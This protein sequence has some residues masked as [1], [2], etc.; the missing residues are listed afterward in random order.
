M[1]VNKSGIWSEA[2]VPGLALGGVSIAYLAINSFTSG[3]AA[4]GT[5]AFLVGFLNFFLW[6]GKLVLCIW[7]LRLF[8]LKFSERRP[9]AGVREIFRY[10]M[11]IALLSSLLYSVFY[12]A[13]VLY[14][15][16]DIIT[17]SFDT[18]LQQYAPMMDQASLEAVENMKSDMPV[19]TFIV[20]LI[21]CFLFGTVLSSIFARRISGGSDNP[22]IDEQ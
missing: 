2:G 21:W 17:N 8:L 18:A 19:A 7:L 6:A 16:P 9:E 1:E 15:N 14:I 4:K 13:Y 11:V 3:L 22:F 12:L 5:A 10:G 20:N